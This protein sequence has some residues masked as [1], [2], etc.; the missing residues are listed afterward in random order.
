M[1][2]IAGK[3]DSV[4]PITMLQPMANQAIDAGMPVE[5]RVKEH[6][7]HTL[8]VGAVLPEAIDWLLKHRLAEPV[9]SN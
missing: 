4:I 9:P 6:L 5:L 1:L 8:L 7:G 2:V 3:L